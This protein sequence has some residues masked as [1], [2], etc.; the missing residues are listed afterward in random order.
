MPRLV[1]RTLHDS[2][3]LRLELVRCDGADGPAEPERAAA[4][5]LVVVLRGRFALRDRDRRLVADPTTPVPLFAGREM[6]IRHP[7][8]CGD[9]CLS[10]RGAPAWRW[11]DARP[12]P[13]PLRAAAQVALVRLCRRLRAGAAVAALEVEE[14]V[15]T[16]LDRA[17][18]PPARRR[19]PSA[20]ER[21]IARAI[22]DALALHP[23]AGLGLRELARGVGLSPYHACRAFRDV[24][25]TSIHRRLVELRLRHALALVLD[26]DWPLARVAFEA[27]FAN[28]GHLGN[29]FRR[30]FGASPG[31]VR[32]GAPLQEGRTNV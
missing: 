32:R 24:E 6:V 25:G 11:L 12:R 20:R 8:G 18:E 14:T 26:T 5:Q 28:E 3:D 30:R 2:D 15:W 19:V 17:P 29:R 22:A 7:E 21:E 31:A 10:V 16:A 13:R 9:E 4:D 27:G 1:A 23:D